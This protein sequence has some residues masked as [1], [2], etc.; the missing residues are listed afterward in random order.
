MTAT[1]L[2]ARAGKLPLFASDLRGLLKLG[3]DATVG[4]T[5]I[6]EAMHHTIGSGSG[7]VGAAPT[8]RTNV[9]TTGITGF[10][11]RTVRGTTTLVGRGLDKVMAPVT[12]RLPPGESTARRDAAMAVLNGI[13]GDHLVATGNPLAI[14]M[15]L[16]CDG[17]PLELS[18]DALAQRFPQASGHVIVLVHG[19]CMNDHQWQRKGHDH[20]QVLA[21]ELGATALYLHYNS[22]RHVADN[23]HD[24]AQVLQRLLSAWPVPLQT[25]TLIGHSMGGLVIRSACLAAEQQKLDWLPRLKQQVFL[26]TPHHGAPL[27]RGGHLI[28]MVLGISPYAA[29][30]ARLGQA[31]SAGITDLRYGNVQRPPGGDRHT[32]AADDRPPSPLPAGVKTFLVAAT[33][34]ETASGLRHH[35]IGDGLV[36]LAS[37]LGEH[38]DPALALGVPSDQTLVVTSANHWDLLDRGEVAEQMLAWLAD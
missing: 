24:F 20:G 19:L 17:Q 28:D 25:L 32:Q 13:W 26:G 12:E 10:V 8:G 4:V 38:R 34:A 30:F 31:R 18:S 37:A 1:P 22:G 35:L 3:V 36:F 11:Y 21:R 6:V 33:T 5:D 16:R 2:P 27:E 14:P 7:I 29:P 9:R 23:G 15:A